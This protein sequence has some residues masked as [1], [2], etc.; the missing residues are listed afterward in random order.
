M[1]HSISLPNEGAMTI[2][3]EIDHIQPSSRYDIEKPYI[4]N[5]ALSSDQESL[6]SNLQYDRHVVTIHDLRTTEWQPSIQDNGFELLQIPSPT[7]SEYFTLPDV[8]IELEGVVA[9][10]QKHFDTPHVFAYDQVVS[11]DFDLPRYNGIDLSASERVAKR[12]S[13]AQTSQIR[14]IIHDRHRSQPTCR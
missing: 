5:T 6:R 1:M 11:L 12:D 4:I 8:T 14:C 3:A 2:Q 10:L 7:M 9:L 13:W